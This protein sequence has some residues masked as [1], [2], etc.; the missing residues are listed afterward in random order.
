MNTYQTASQATGVARTLSRHSACTIVIYKMSE[1][2]FV[3]ARP[4]DPMLGSI[5]GVYRNGYVVPTL[6]SKAS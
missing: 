6:F 1:S 2:Q 3:T 5:E 4:S